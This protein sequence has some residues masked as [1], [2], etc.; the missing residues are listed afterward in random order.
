MKTALANFTWDV[1]GK[2]KMEH[3]DMFDLSG[4][5]GADG[6]ISEAKRKEI[7]C[8]MDKAPFVENVAELLTLDFL[9]FN[10]VKQNQMECPVDPSIQLID[11]KLNVFGP[12]EDDFYAVE[13]KLIKN[14]RRGNTVLV[15]D[16]KHIMGRKGL[17]KFFDLRM[18][19]VDKAE[20]NQLS[21]KNTKEIYHMEK[22]LILAPVLRSIA[23][24]EQV[25]VFKT[26][27]ANGENV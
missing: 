10:I 4:A 25:E 23:Q 1:V 7:I 15:K 24:G 20:R 8:F 14:V 2:L 26:L 17:L 6:R 13:P 11:L 21:I 22:N 16:G 19:F 3:K 12:Q 18:A 9:G 5:L 27:K